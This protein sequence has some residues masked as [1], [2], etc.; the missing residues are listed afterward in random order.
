MSLCAQFV[1]MAEYNQWMNARVY[2]A[3]GRLSREE[4][5]R[6]RGAFFGSILGTL[7]HLVV[8]D[9]T[10]L[11]RFAAHPARPPVL[12]ALEGWP[13][14]TALAQ[15]L[16]DELEPLREQRQQ[17][18]RLIRD[19]AGMLRDDDLGQPLSYRNMQGVA[20]R[21]PFSSLV[22]HF[23]NHQAH[24]RGQVSTLLTQAGQDL[25][26]TDLLM[27]IPNDAEA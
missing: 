17:M 22:L 24:H 19:W 20:A 18:D 27:L 3:A 2:A 13:V 6:N 4:F 9:L 11:R 12:D 21:R 14:P 5:A 23:F 25:G 15:V 26:V 10:W 7:N 16:F 8:A 1:L